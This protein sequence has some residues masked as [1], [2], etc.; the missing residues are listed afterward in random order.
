MTFL[1]LCRAAASE[2]G[3]SQT[4]PTDTTTQTGRLLQIVNWVNRS[5]L[6]IQQKRND[7]RFMVGNFTL[8]TTAGTRKYV[9][10]DCTDTAAAAAISSFREWCTDSMRIFLASAGQ[11]SETELDFIDYR[12][13]HRIYNVGTPALSTT[14]SYPRTFTV[15]NDL[16]LLLSQYPDAAY[17]ISGRYMKA[18]SEMVGDDGTPA[19]PAEYHMAIVYRTMMKYGR[20]IGASEV[21]SDG[22]A[23]YTRAIREIL[24]T[25]TLPPL[26]VGPLA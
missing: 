3:V 26:A 14:R 5:W 7:W 21:Y 9:A 8:N 22:K 16:G 11:G 20:Y 17:T 10:S 19:L 18:A 12:D 13:W 4:G 1:E 2:C 24:R 6:E 15:D 23:E 25:Q